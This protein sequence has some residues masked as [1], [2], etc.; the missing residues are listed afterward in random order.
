[1]GK[2]ALPH[3]IYPFS[4]GNGRMSRLGQTAMLVTGCSLF[5]YLLIENFIKYFQVNYYA[6]IDASNKGGKIQ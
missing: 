6:S 1:M 5:F 3:D 4:D 2:Y